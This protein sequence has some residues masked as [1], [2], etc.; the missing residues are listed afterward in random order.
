MHWNVSIVSNQFA[1]L[2]GSDELIHQISLAVDAPEGILPD[3]THVIKTEA[4]KKTL[5]IAL[6]DDVTPTWKVMEK[7]KSRPSLSYCTR[8][9]TK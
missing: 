9:L 8:L 2:E 6:S 7:V 3:R 5:D 1:T 4:G